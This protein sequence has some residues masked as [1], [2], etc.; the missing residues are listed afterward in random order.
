MH[1]QKMKEVAL[2]RT[3]QCKTDTPLRKDDNQQTDRCFRSRNGPTTCLLLQVLRTCRQKNFLFVFYGPGCC[4]VRWQ[5][6]WCLCNFFLPLSLQSFLFAFY[7]SFCSSTQRC[8]INVT[9]LTFVLYFSKNQ[10]PQVHC[11]CGLLYLFRVRGFGLRTEY[12]SLAQSENATRSMQV[13]SDSNGKHIVGGRS[14]CHTRK[15][16]M[17]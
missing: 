14:E 4:V 15:E 12:K 2:H 5:G 13:E 8:S 9:T 17:E 11:F 10:L 6:K 7:L 3:E 1:K 16:A